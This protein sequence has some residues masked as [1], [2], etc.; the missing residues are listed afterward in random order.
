MITQTHHKGISDI[1]QLNGTVNIISQGKHVREVAVQVCEM[2]Q[3]SCMN[4]Q[5]KSDI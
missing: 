3:F 5:N 4:L 2:L 1:N